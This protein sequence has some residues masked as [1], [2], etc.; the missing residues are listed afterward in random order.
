MEDQQ[1]LGALDSPQHEAPLS[2]TPLTEPDEQVTGR[3]TFCR[4]FSELAEHAVV[5]T[6]GSC[7][8][9]VTL[10][11]P[12]GGPLTE[13]PE[14][15]ASAVTHP[16]VSELVAVQWESEEGP[17]PEALESGE[18]VLVR[19][20]RHETRWPRYRAMAL[21]RGLRACATL[22]FRHEGAVL[23]VSVYA[24]RPDGL[25]GVVEGKSAELAGLAEQVVRSHGRGA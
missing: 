22:P 23:T 19:D 10:T 8:A 25:S 9:A 6:S 20:V 18:P 12:A 17:V 2:A 11:D 5:S 13:S 3:A 1:R 16:E 21:Q 4:G 14:G 15:R 7:A 24:F